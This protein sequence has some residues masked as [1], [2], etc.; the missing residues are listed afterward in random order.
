MHW[1]TSPGVKYLHEQPI[2]PTT[3]KIYILKEITNKTTGKTY[4]KTTGQDYM[5]RPFLCGHRSYSCG[6]MFKR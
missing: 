4:E 6:C 2:C 5:R 3:S 1:E